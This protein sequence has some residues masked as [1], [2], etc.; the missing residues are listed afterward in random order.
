MEVFLSTPDHFAI[1]ILDEVRFGL[2]QLFYDLAWVPCVGVWCLIYYVGA[3]WVFVSGLLAVPF[4]Q[5]T[6]SCCESGTLIAYGIYGLVG[7]MHQP[8]QYVW[9]DCLPMVQFSQDM[10][11]LLLVCVAQ[12]S[13]LVIHACQLWVMSG[14]G[15]FS[16]SYFLPLS[17]MLLLSCLIVG[18]MGCLSHALSPFF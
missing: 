9:G 17:H 1:I 11:C 2:F 12:V 7:V 10:A 14:T 6:G 13:Q 18:G 3:Q 15:V 4:R 5:S 8:F 16:S